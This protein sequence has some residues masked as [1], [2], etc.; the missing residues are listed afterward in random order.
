MDDQL[1]AMESSAVNTGNKLADKELEITRLTEET[2]KLK[3]EVAQLEAVNESLQAQV[4]MIYGKSVNLYARVNEDKV[5]LRDRPDTGG[6][7]I[8]ELKRGTTVLVVKEVI[9][10]KNESWAAVDVNGQSGYIMMKYLDLEKEDE[11]G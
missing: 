2:E 4:D 9:N 10:N 11:N 3:N 1:K 8:R 6:R 5:R 7:R